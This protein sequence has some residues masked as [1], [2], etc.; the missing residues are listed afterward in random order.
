MFIRELKARDPGIF[1]WEIKDRLV[2]EEICDKFN[3]PSVSSISRILRNKMNP[4]ASVSAHSEDAGPSASS[5]STTIGNKQIGLYKSDSA[6]DC[7]GPCEPNNPQC[8]T[9]GS[10]A[11]LQHDS[12]AQPSGDQVHWL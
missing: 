4:K 12:T 8:G 9:K 3:V 6:C 7:E 2:N 5:T 10:G 1:A 11:A